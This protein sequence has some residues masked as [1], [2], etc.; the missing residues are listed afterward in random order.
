MRK[1]LGTLIRLAHRPPTW[2]FWSAM[3]LF[4]T[5]GTPARAEWLFDVAAGASYD[6]NL[7]RAANAS[8]VRPGFAATFD[9]SAGQFIAMTGN[10]T[11]TLIANA[12][13][14]SYARY[15]GLDV[16]GIGTTAVYRHKFGLGWGAPWAAFS[17][18]GAYDEYRSE[19]RDGARFDVRAEVGRRFTRRLDAVVGIACD[20]R[21]AP[22]GDPEVPG[23]PGN[24][25]ALAGQRAFVRASYALGEQWLFSI[26]G[27][28]RRGD[29]ESTSQQGAAV[30]AASS[31]IAEDPAFGDPRLYAYRLRGTTATLGATLN[32]AL[33]EHSSLDLRY[34]YA[35]TRSPQYLDYRSNNVELVFAYRL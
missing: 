2:K 29:V 18:M 6:S 17:V 27:A 20:R 9:V 1:S 14:E 5:L 24:V 21:Y 34:R 32:F 11:V 23:I 12:R 3:V 28:I 35:S 15:R 30:F 7:T 31:A 10:D 16:A 19:I 22:N 33:N 4:A 26:D 25:F 8:D 13:G